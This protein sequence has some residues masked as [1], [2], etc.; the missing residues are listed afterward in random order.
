MRSESVSS[1]APEAIDFPPSPTSSLSYRLRR[2]ISK[3]LLRDAKKAD[4]PLPPLP[5]SP[6]EAKAEPDLV[7]EDP[8]AGYRPSQYSEQLDFGD[9]PSRRALAPSRWSSSTECLA[10]PRRRWGSAL[11]LRQL[12]K[13]SR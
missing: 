7:G 1:Y 5:L 8:F 4:T 2:V 6:T 13:R 10:A 11:S 9:R 3:P 12:F